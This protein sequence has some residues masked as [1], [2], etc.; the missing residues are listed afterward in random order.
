M[1]RESLR[2]ICKAGGAET[3]ERKSLPAG[4]L[5][6]LLVSLRRGLPRLHLRQLSP[7]QPALGHDP[8]S[9]QS[10]QYFNGSYEVRD[11]P[12]PSTFR[13]FLFSDRIRKLLYTKSY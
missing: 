10:Q 11:S 9:D 5:A 1:Y 7:S 12:R 6:P 13:I 3:V 8:R 4:R 2:N